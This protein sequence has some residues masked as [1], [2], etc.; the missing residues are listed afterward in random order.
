MGDVVV[1]RM[2]AADLAWA[3]G[4]LTTYNASAMTAADRAAHGFVQGSFTAEKI[5]ALTAGAGGYVAEVDGVAAGLVLTSVAGHATAGPA[6]QL[7]ALAAARFGPAGYLMYGPVVVDAAFR[8]RGV[9]RALYEAVRTGAAGRARV[10]VCF[11]DDENPVSLAAHTRL[12][13]R[14]FAVYTTGARGYHALW[15]DIPA[16]AGGRPD[17]VS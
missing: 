9:L 14:E 13:M 15:F 12:G 3:A 6:G 10:G 5:A 2:D 4:L 16:L 1:R 17:S 8:R 7:A 11:V